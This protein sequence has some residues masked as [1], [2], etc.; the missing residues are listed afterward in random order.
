MNKYDISGFDNLVLLVL[1]YCKGKDRSLVIDN[2]SLNT[3]ILYTN[4]FK[5]I[6]FNSNVENV[7]CY[8]TFSSV[9]S[10]YSKNMFF[11]KNN[12]KIDT[13]KDEN[14][15]C[16]FFEKKLYYEKLSYVSVEPDSDVIAKLTKENEELK[17]K[18]KSDSDI[19]VKLSKEI[20]ELK[21]KDKSD[22][23]IIAKLTKEN[24]DLKLK[25]EKLV[26]KYNEIEPLLN[27]I[28]SELDNMQ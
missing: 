23:D 2:P 24:D 1:P 12:F 8:L 21:S 18:D 17:S 22:S 25:Y 7:Y 13:Q 3:I 6:K 15:N 19:I 16:V 14:F 9:S 26:S 10:L 11:S 5:I 27:S 28:L 20:E 4:S